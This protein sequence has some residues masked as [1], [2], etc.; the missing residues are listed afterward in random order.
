MA[1]TARTWSINGLATETGLDRRTIGRL[2]GD[3]KS[4]GAGPCGPTYRMRDVVR[5]IR[6]ACYSGESEQADAADKAV[7]AVLRSRRWKTRLDV[8][9]SQLAEADSAV[10]ARL[11]R[12]CIAELAFLVATHYERRAPKI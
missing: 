8:Y 2:V 7:A 5:A 9:A 12:A 1:M 4:S 6:E 10:R 3:L 11:L